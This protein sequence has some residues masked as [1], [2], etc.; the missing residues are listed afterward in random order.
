MTSFA[1][2]LSKALRHRIDQT[3]VCEADWFRQYPKTNMK[4]GFGGW[5]LDFFRAVKWPF[6]APSRLKEHNWFCQ[7]DLAPFDG[8]IWPHLFSFV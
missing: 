3:A 5:S 7:L 2:C 6:R 8:L 1:P 4:P